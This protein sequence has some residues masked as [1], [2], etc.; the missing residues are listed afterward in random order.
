[1]ELLV[2]SYNIIGTEPLQLGAVLGG[3]KLAGLPQ[4][5]FGNAVHALGIAGGVLGDGT[6]MIPHLVHG[7]HHGQLLQPALHHLAQK[8]H[9]GGN[10][11]HVGGGV[12][13]KAIAPGHVQAYI[14]AAQVLEHLRVVLEQIQ[15]AEL[16]PGINV[17]LPHVHGR[18][19]RAAIQQA[20]HG[21]LTDITGCAGNKHLFCH[22]F[23]F[24][25]LSPHPSWCRE[26]H[27]HFP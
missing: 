20:L 6:L 25:M 2:V 5:V 23:S 8:A 15:M 11:L 22:R 14:R 9:M 7:S 19:L 24:I 1:M 12:V 18:Y 27:V 4:G 13:H 3:Q 10:V 21:G 16:R 26:K 17:L